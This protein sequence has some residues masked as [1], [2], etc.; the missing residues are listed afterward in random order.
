MLR[1]DTI[2][3]GI[4]YALLGLLFFPAQGLTQGKMAATRLDTPL[5]VDGST[6]DWPELMLGNPETGFTY[7]FAYNDQSLFICLEA[8][9]TNLQNRILITGLFVTIKSGPFSPAQTLLIPYGLPEKERPND[10][11]ALPLILSSLQNVKEKVLVGMNQGLPETF[12]QKSGG[13]EPIKTGGISA[14]AYFDEA[15]ILFYEA[16]IPWSWVNKAKPGGPLSIEIATGA[17]GRPVIPESL[18]L[19]ELVQ[20]R[21]QQRRQEYWDFYRQFTVPIRLVRKVSFR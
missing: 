15:G 3:T 12:I 7:N 8:A 18:G 20:T 5:V 2:W 11:M 13:R 10:P 4:F 6:A 1:K 14:N 16:A 9:D 19:T 21:E 17:L